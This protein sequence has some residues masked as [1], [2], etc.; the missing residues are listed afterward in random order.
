MKRSLL[1]TTALLLTTSFVAPLNA[2]TADT[3]LSGEREVAQQP[4][5]NS[6]AN[7]ARVL[8]AYFQAIAD[9]NYQAAY[10]LHSPEYRAQVPYDVFV[11][12]YQ[13]HIQ[14]I[15][16]QSVEPLPHFSNPNHQEFRVEFNVSYIKPFP[17]GNGRIP[18]F[19][20]LVPQA[21]D[22]APWLIDGMAPG[23]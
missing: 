13:D 16:I 8:Y 20:V 2:Q 11:Q 17:A 3:G 12:M 5:S 23:P 14:S 22:Q 7:A 15:S 10:N 18:E 4:A 1:V 6:S 19:F 9:Q 21:D